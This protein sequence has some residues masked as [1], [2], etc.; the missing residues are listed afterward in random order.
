MK[1]HSAIGLLLV[2]LSCVVE[3]LNPEIKALF[4]DFAYMDMEDNNFREA[5]GNAAAEMTPEKIWNWNSTYGYKDDEDRLPEHDVINMTLDMYNRIRNNEG[6]ESKEIWFLAVVTP[7]YPELHHSRS[8]MF[9]MRYLAEM[10][11]G[12][13]RFAIMLQETWAGW[14]LIQMTDTYALPNIWLIVPDGN[15]DHDMYEMLPLMTDIEGFV[16]FIENKDNGLEKMTYMK[17]KMPAELGHYE[18]VYRNW[19]RWWRHE[20]MREEEKARSFLMEN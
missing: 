19:Y 7:K 16:R 13:Y 8:T 1:L 5:F 12:R 20:W 2:T 10:Y 4:K 3:A 15:N 9:N 11:Q 17:Y 14:N 18:F 6:P